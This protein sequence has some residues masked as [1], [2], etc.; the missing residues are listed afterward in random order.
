MIEVYG[1]IDEFLKDKFEYKDVYEEFVDFIKGV[2]LVVY[3][4]LFDVGFMDYEFVKFGGVIGK[5]SD[6]CKVIDI[7]VMVKWIFFGKCNNLDILC[8][9]YGIDNLYWILY[10]VLFDVE[11]LVDVYLLMTGG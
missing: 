8:E 3:N 4:V 11:I 5:I 9:C 7:L 1:I 2:E 6:F 10:G